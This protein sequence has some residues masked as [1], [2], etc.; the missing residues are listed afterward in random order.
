M[1]SADELCS[2]S[3]NDT[4]VKVIKGKHRKAHR[5]IKVSTPGS[6][7]VGS[8]LRRLRCAKV[9]GKARDRAEG[10]P[11]DDRGGCSNDDS[12][13]ACSLNEVDSED[14]C[15]GNDGSFINLPLDS[16][17]DIGLQNSPVAKSC[18]LKTS[19]E[20]TSMGMLAILVLG[21]CS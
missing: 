9:A 17:P 20:H 3:L 4:K 6:A 10:F 5:G 14:L 7:G 18:G 11:H 2:T 1:T 16:S 8:I 19:H 13:V 15:K 12:I 21:R